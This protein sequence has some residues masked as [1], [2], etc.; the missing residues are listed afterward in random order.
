MNYQV[1]IVDDEALAIRGIEAGVDWEKIG[2]AQVF[3]ASN[4][5]QAKEILKNQAID[6]M[7]CDIEMPQGNGLEL[8]AWVRDN[9][10]AVE[11]IIL[12]CHA[13]FDYARKALQL[14]SL[15]YMLKAIPYSDLEAIILR[16]IAKLEKDR[17]LT[18]SS[19]YGELWQKNQPLLLEQFWADI[20]S[21]VISASAE[22]IQ[23][24]SVERG[25]IFTDDIDVLPLLVYYIRPEKDQASDSI[26]KALLENLRSVF[27][28]EKHPERQLHVIQ[29]SQDSL[30]FV[31]S[32][33]HAEDGKPQNI[34]PALLKYCYDL[35]R[36]TGYDLYFYVGNV[37]KADSL[38]LTVCQIKTLA[39]NDVALSS[40]VGFL[41]EQIEKP[42]QVKGFDLNIW[43]D[44]IAEKAYGRLIDEV[45]G[46]LG[47]LVSSG[48]IDKHT[49][50]QFH[51]DF[52]QMIYSMLRQ[53]KIQA[54]LL[55][56]DEISN[57]LFERSS[58]TVKDMLN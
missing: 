28:M 13:D 35:R 37:V 55:L 23:Q 44:M 16:A 24:A 30:L 58:L 51:Q 20:A 43:S 9:R 21:G 25:I 10:L 4:I 12:T 52:L 2:V 40:N 31:I 1:L 48:S 27:S 56:D 42:A 45:S 3:T 17:E 49:L 6:I 57:K 7:L 14:G 11:T 8:L 47:E 5:R 29:R 34:L 15:D 38:A 54:H 50:Q 53:K 32:A 41:G 18:Q 36:Q 33:L 19:Q 22:I 46:Y 26:E 39:E